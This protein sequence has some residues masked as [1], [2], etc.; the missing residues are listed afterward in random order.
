MARTHLLGPRLFIQNCAIKSKSAR[1]HGS[2]SADLR[3]KVRGSSCEKSTNLNEG[4]LPP[5]SDA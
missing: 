5:D 4:G 2:R 1:A 3:F